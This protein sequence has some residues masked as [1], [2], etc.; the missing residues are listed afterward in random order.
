MNEL[1][2]QMVMEEIII[3][4]VSRRK[5]TRDYEGKQKFQ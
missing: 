1:L 2:N 5:I 3:K 4:G